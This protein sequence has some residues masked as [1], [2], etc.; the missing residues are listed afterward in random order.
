MRITTI[1]LALI[2][3]SVVVLG[4]GTFFN[5][6][7]IGLV[8]DDN[9]S[10][11]YDRLNN[12]SPIY[13]EVDDTIKATG[14]GDSQGNFLVNLGS[15]WASVKIFFTSF[16]DVSEV[17][18]DAAFDLKIPDWLRFALLATVTILFLGLLINIAV[19]WKAS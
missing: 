14:A 11:T 6:A 19:R 9:T 15:M 7:N 5:T 17:T 3:L 2:L 13:Q 1:P 10:A 12:I 8:G 4:L 18:E 16:G